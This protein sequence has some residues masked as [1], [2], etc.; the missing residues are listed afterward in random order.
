M[1]RV[2]SPKKTR[3]PGRILLPLVILTIALVGFFIRFD[4]ISHWQN[5]KLHYFTENGLPITLGADP[6]YYID[7]ADNLRHGKIIK[8]D[9]HRYYP[10]GGERV[11]A[12]PLLSVVLAATS[13]ITNQPL[14]WIA[15]YIPPFLG[16]L[17]VIPL[18]LLAVMLAT[19]SH[20]P[21]SRGKPISQLEAWSFG[22]LA[23]LFSLISMPFVTRSS[24]GWCDTDI[25]NPTFA[26][27]GICLAAY[28]VYGSENKHEPL[29]WFLYWAISFLAF[30]WWWDQGFVPVLVIAGT[31]ML[32]A[33][34]FKKAHIIRNKR[35]YIALIVFLLV[36]LVAWK[37]SSL[38]K[39]PQSFLSLY[40]YVMGDTK[41]S[42]FPAFEKYVDE[43]SDREFLQI[44]GD[45]A[46]SHYIYFVAIAGL[47]FLLVITKKNML[48]LL[49]LLG[50]NILSFKGVRFMIFSAPLFG[51]GMAAFFLALLLITRRMGIMRFILLLPLV[52]L[53]A[54]PSLS[55]SQ[56]YNFSKPLFSP[57]IFD[58]MQKI[59]EVTE[60]NSII[61]SSWGH[62]HP[63]VYYAERA[64]IGDGV[65]HSASL[66]FATKFPF[67]ANNFR[68]AANWIQFYTVYGQ[69]GVRK[70]FTL[71]T[72]DESDWVKG[73]NALQE[74]FAGG[75]GDSREILTDRYNM[76]STEV[77]NFLSFLFPDEAP[78]IYIFI[79]Y[80]LLTEGWYYVGKWNFAEKSPPRNFTAIPVPFFVINPS[81]VQGYT[82][83]GP[84]QVNLTEGLT[85]FSNR[86]PGKISEIYIT[87]DQNVYRR[88]Y[89]ATG[90]L[91]DVYLTKNTVDNYMFGFLADSRV[92]ESV[93]VK[94]FFEKEPAN[95]FFELADSKLS[96]Y[97][98][99]KVNAEKYSSAGEYIR[100][101]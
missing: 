59:S 70:A 3:T 58:G 37:G 60:D 90:G 32:F 12:A 51:L 96:L 80:M 11:S 17:L 82:A 53:C 61:W 47:V 89:H 63:L 65:F 83:L 14:E 85:L 42:V 93:L 40:S 18:Y 100:P 52:F 74:I 62:G 88:K 5:N 54:W 99:Y 38:Y 49:P 27:L 81:N 43:Q 57:K 97:K 23:A 79:D 33:V 24:I 67:A 98:L 46:G 50:L 69:K 21:W 92:K 87:T 44:A 30:A 64:T 28:Y 78:P 36:I 6:Y 34:L 72:G 1:K 8:V 101:N 95:N 15:V 13:F 26:T 56:K 39:M 94:L 7:I 68:L 16:I 66:D 29:R 48:L 4:N 73:F 41:E 84:F 71:L 20:V 9:P 76:A 75:V 55:L 77:E 25:L 91:L 86:S 2:H 22:C 35:K 10:D 19:Y 45:I 31:P